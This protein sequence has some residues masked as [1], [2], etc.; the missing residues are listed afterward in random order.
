M[1]MNELL[2]GENSVLPDSQKYLCHIKGQ[3]HPTD[4]RASVYLLAGKGVKSKMAGFTLHTLS[5]VGLFK[6]LQIPNGFPLCM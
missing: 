2:Q 1:Y 5:H 6:A 4:A 3:Q